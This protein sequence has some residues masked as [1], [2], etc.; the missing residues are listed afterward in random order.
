[1]SA[2]LMLD[3]LGETAAAL[4]LERAV[5][6]VLVEGEIRTYDLGGNSSTTEMTDAISERLA[7]PHSFDHPAKSD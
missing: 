2:K 4:R 7:A 5:R 1:M 3:Y 6:D